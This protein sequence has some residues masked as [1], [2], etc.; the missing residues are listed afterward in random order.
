MSRRLP[1]TAVILVVFCS[2]FA[3]FGQA[4]GVELQ[5]IVLLSPEI[6]VARLGELQNS[7]KNLANDYSLKPFTRFD[8][9]AAAANGNPLITPQMYIKALGNENDYIPLMTMLRESR[10][11][12]QTILLT[13]K[14]K[15][16]DDGSLAGM[17][18]AVAA[19]AAI[20]RDL[21]MQQMLKNYE[22]E[23]ENCNI[24]G[25]NKESDA[26][27]ALAF[28]QVDA[29]LILSDVSQLLSTLSP[30]LANNIVTLYQT[31]VLYTS[32]LWI[33]SSLC[34]S[35]C[36]QKIKDLFLA[37]PNEP[38]G[39]DILRLMNCRGWQTVEGR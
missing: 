5:E 29:A 12:S 10:T 19:P 7:W 20:A 31:E 24:I 39:R 2:C 18:I 13:K 16:G 36:R 14:G 21:V 11:K 38:A 1:L 27:F 30:G 33:S 26:F 37:F 3:L 17:T 25:V 32:Q 22:G 8:D 6:S 4:K 23:L 9:F 15:V 35:G 34:D 28:G